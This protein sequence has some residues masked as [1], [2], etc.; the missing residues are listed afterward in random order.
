[1]RGM[2]LNVRT[3]E[4]VQIYWVSGLNAEL[5]ENIQLY[6][7]DPSSS[8]FLELPESVACHAHASVD[9]LLRS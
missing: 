2:P 3:S 7:T 5:S 1:V 9:F 6:R 4:N 8:L